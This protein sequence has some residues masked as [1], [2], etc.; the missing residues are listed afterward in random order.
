MINIAIRGKHLS[1]ITADDITL[2]ELKDILIDY[3]NKKTLTM[4]KSGFLVGGLHF[5]TQTNR[6]AKYDGM[7]LMKDYLTYPF[8]IRSEEGDKFNFTSSADVVSFYGTLFSQIF[9]NEK[10]ASEIIDSIYAAEDFDEI[11]L[12]DDNR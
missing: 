10:A 4:E 2:E 1:E 12:V 8:S 3:V 11:K 6:I 9:L 7:L 5:H